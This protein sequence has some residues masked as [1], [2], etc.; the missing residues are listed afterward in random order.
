MEIENAPPTQRTEFI[1][2]DG[3]SWLC[4]GGCG[5]PTKINQ[6]CE[7]CSVITKCCRKPAYLCKTPVIFICKR[8][9]A[10]VGNPHFCKE[11][12]KNHFDVMKAERKINHVVSQR[13]EAVKEI[14]KLQA[15]L[16]QCDEALESCEEFFRTASA[17]RNHILTEEETKAQIAEL[18]WE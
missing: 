17:A 4:Q 14:A 1:S 6:V 7:F 3:G 11:C 12:K 8:G 15:A 16:L 13:V 2:A 9:H 10:Q 18:T 5:T